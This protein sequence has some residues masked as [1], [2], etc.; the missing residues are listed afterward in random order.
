MEQKLDSLSNWFASI[1]R[2]WGL[3]GSFL[4]NPISDY[5]LF[6]L[7]SVFGIV[8]IKIVRYYVLKLV[9]KIGHNK[10]QTLFRFLLV[11]LKKSLKPIEYFGIMYFA[12]DILRI[13]HKI[14]RGIDIIGV[15]IITFYTVKF[16]IAILDYIIEQKF[17]KDKTPTKA[18]ILKSLLPAV[19]FIIWGMGFVFVLSNI[20]FDITALVAGLGVGGVAV[21]FAAQALL[22]DLFSYVA[23]ITDKPFEIGDTLVV[24]NFTGT[25]AH[26]GI[27]TTRL[28][29]LTGEELIFSNSDLTKSR[30]H[31]MKRMEKRRAQ[32]DI[33]VVYDTKPE[34][35]ERIPLIVQDIISEF[36]D[37]S[38]DRCTFANYGAHSL[39][40]V[41]AYF[42]EGNDVKIYWERVHKVN[43]R[44]KE[45]FTK[46]EIEFAFPTNTVYLKQ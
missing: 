9:E 22:G 1:F 10:N 5:V 30:L 41:A 13:N 4:H 16:L 29:S 31:N 15:I 2:A 11:H 27:K 32:I 17:N 14:E 43:I 37:L 21:A 28:V 26:I 23:I 38:F 33:G 42:V 34:L 20:G 6:V 3:E 39:N 46:A 25:V 7:I 12:K 35:L 36:E 24:D 18:Q 45:E 8:A 40:Y 19:N 44:I